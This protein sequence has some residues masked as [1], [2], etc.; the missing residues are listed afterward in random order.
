VSENSGR[1]HHRPHL[2]GRSL[3]PD[4]RTISTH[5]TSQPETCASASSCREAR[6]D[7]IWFAGD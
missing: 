4:L 5:I 2:D 6:D 3:S 1:P 7:K